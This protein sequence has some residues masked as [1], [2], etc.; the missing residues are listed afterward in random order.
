MHLAFY[1]WGEG[2]RLMKRIRIFA[3]AWSVILALVLVVGTV[4][5]ASILKAL[6]NSI[7]VVSAARGTIALDKVAAPTGVALGLITLLMFF[8][9]TMVEPSNIV[10]A[11]P[12]YVEDTGISSHLAC[13]VCGRKSGLLTMY[14]AHLDSRPLRRSIDQSVRG[15]S[16]RHRTGVDSG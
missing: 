16:R 5:Y 12:D 15:A 3:V 13:E 9:L 1:L 11:E 4:G 14:D 10:V 7:V 2:E 8:A 6:E